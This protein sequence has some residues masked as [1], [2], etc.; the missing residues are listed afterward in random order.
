[1]DS[2][3]GQIDTLKRSLKQ[4]ESKISEAKTKKD[5]LKA[6][7]QAAKAQEQIQ[8]AV[9]KV[10]SNSAMAAFERMEEKVLNQEAHS[11]ALA[12][13]AVNDLETKFVALSAGAD[14]EDELEMMKRQLSGSSPAQAALP[15]AD[16]ASAAPSNAVPADAALDPE[17]E[18]LRKKIDNL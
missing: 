9:G 6:R 15:G 17:I 4:I 1:L 5:M 11:Q 10:G 18:E 16:P 14:V 7:S 2:Q 3:V 13:L 8:G 12:E